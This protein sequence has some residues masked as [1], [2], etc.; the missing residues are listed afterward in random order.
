MITERRIIIIGKVGAGKSSLG[1]EILKKN[2]FESRHSFAP[3]TAEWKSDFS[4]R[5]GIKYFVVDT[6]GVNGIKD[7]S[8]NAFKHIARCFLAT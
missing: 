8:K 5:N 4:V 2:A 6:P 1:N 7:D 3:V